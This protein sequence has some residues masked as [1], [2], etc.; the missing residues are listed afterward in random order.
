MFN[1]GRQFPM[2]IMIVDDGI[3]NVRLV[4]EAVKGLAE[5]IF[6]T[7]GAAAVQLAFD[8]K[9]DVILLDIE[10]PEMDG[11]AVCKAIKSNP[12]MANCSIIFVTG[13]A[14]E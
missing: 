6:T 8:N 13:H 10:M 1:S 2:L 9:P 14:N 4:N 11:F 7:E 5:V 3:H 12:A